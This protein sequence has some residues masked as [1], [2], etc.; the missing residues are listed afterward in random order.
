MSDV[1][2]NAAGTQPVDRSTL[3]DLLA[4]ERR[5]HVLDCLCEHGPTTLPD[6]AEVVA[7]REH[8]DPLPQ[9]PED[10]VL[11]TYLSLYH[12]HVPKLEDG[13]VASYDQDRDVVAL[14]DALDDDSVD[15][16]DSLDPVGAD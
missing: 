9:V 13:G 12:T 6:L 16:V 8:D 10:A 15:E 7:E 14:A 3:H 11:T 5:R 4:S 2:P 1:E